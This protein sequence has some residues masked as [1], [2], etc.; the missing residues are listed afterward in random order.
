[1]NKSTKAIVTIPG[2][3]EALMDAEHMHNEQQAFAS[4]PLI[5]RAINL[6]CDTLTSCPVHVY[7]GEGDN[8]AETDW[9]LPQEMVDL[10]WLTEASMLLSGAAYWLKLKN[11]ANL[12]KDGVQWLNPATMTVELGNKNEIIFKQDK[13]TQNT[14]P[15]TL[16][17]MVY[18]KDF[19]PSNDVGPGVSP[20][21][22]SLGASSLMRYMTDFASVFF[23]KGAMPI[24]VLG[25][26]GLTD[27]DEIKR[28]EGFFKK[29]ASGVK[30]AFRTVAVNTEKLDPKVLSQP[31]KDLAMPEL[32][33]Q[34]RHN[35]AWAFGIPQTMLEDSANYA[36]A[37][38]HRMSFWQDTLRPRGNKIARVINKQL[39]EPHFGMTMEFAFDELDI[40]QEDEEKRSDSY[41]NY[42][43][44]GMRPSIAA[45]ILG[46]DL[47]EGVDYADLDDKYDQ[48]EQEMD[49]DDRPINDSNDEKRVKDELRKWLRFELRRLGKDDKREFKSAV[50]P[51]SMYGAISGSLQTAD[52]E[53][54]VKRIFDDAIKWGTYA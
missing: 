34:A 52:N 13:A 49:A 2:W 46:I 51:L 43:G 29:I 33:E 53:D 26:Q 5:F 20:T 8:R 1:L 50:I 38:E 40:F 14:G 17:E 16:K 9:P 48:P 47:P 4:V 22:V 19:N 31:V 3:A 39:L 6:R 32:T 21:E 44:A 28:V 27:K 37:K 54:A 30:N 42:V 25:V 24:T 23:E 41:Y 35:I 12:L 11:K 7:K 36:T 15:W 18:F 45:E 10:L